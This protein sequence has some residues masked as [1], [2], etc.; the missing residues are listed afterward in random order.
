ML[1]PVAIT[2][3]SLHLMVPFLANQIRS[4]HYDL[5]YVLDAAA[6]LFLVG[7]A[8]LLI[9]SVSLLGKPYWRHFLLP[10]LIVA[11]SFL[12]YALPYTTTYPGSDWYVPNYMG[13]TFIAGGVIFAVGCWLIILKSSK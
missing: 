3:L 7:M 2:M 12:L 9:W 5:A 11:G 6:L 10:P 4:H 8:V 1:L 13:L